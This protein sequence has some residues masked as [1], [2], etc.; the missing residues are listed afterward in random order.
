MVYSPLTNEIMPPIGRYKG[1]KKWS[2]RPKGVRINGLNVHHHA[3]TNDSGIRRLV[4]SSDPAS[5]NYIIRNN[6]S[7]IGSVP[8]EY[9]AWTTSAYANDDDKITVEIQNETGAPDWR[10]SAAAMDTLV[11]LY[12]DIAQRYRFAPV[13]ASLKGHQEY[14]VATACPGPY[15]LP[16][17]DDVARKAAALGGVV[18]G[19]GGA[20]APAPKPSGPAKID[21]DGKWGTGTTTRLQQVLGMA[22]VDGEVSRQSATWR[23]DNPGCTTGWD[24]TGKT[25]DGGSPTIRRHQEILRDRGRYKGAIDGKAGPQYFT[26]LQQDLGTKADGELWKPSAAVEA[27]QKRLNTGRV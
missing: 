26:A 16:R 11:R 24:W 1:G 27:L 12:A 23:D 22:V 8:E 15:L 19:G 17:L 2:A 7:L 6:G 18:S 14:G 3:A 21:V 5:A 25:G 20:S 4:T 10:I 9:R 13:R